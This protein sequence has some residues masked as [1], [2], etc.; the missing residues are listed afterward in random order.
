MPGRFAAVLGSP[1]R[2]SLSPV[3]HR[4]A[5][6]ALGL[7]GWRYEAIECTEA[8][9]PTLLDGHP[10]AAGF[11]VTMPLKRAAL[12]LADAAGE[13][14]VRIGASNT[15]LRRDAGWYAE[16]TDWRGIRDA[17]AER[18]ITPQRVVV[19]GAGGTAQAA[20]AALTGVAE[21]TVLVREPARAGELL[22][23]ADRLSCRIELGR[24][25]ELEPADL[26]ISTL[27]PGAADDLA[28]RLTPGCTVLDVVYAGWPTPLAR[29]AER[30][31]ARAISGAAM[32]LHQAGGQVELM[33]GRA[34]PIEAMRA[35]M[36]AAVPDCGC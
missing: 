36:R 8:E 32:L 31:G 26:L 13:L 11:S 14:A 12:R 30:A 2:H 4:A 33:T 7:T 9:L 21:I 20:L 17:L 24:L 22:A 18:G 10:D 34:A 25:T 5:Y 35:A 23:A 15:L 6:A 29:A 19:L 27:P 3:L 16:N 28:V 1:I